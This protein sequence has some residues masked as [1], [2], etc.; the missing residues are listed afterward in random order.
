MC[1]CVCVV[2]GGGGCDPQA[3]PPGSGHDIHA[4]THPLVLH[5]P[6]R[7]DSTPSGS[8]SRV[9]LHP[10]LLS[11]QE[12]EVLFAKAHLVIRMIQLKIGQDLLLQVKNKQFT[13]SLSL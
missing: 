4:H 9:N 7:A 12:L 2:G 8:G 6:Y 5:T 11:G 3:S 10:K 1:V 13:V